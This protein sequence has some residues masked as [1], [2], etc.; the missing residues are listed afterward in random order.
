[1]DDQWLKKQAG[2]EVS[3]FLKE[4]KSAGGFGPVP[5]EMLSSARTDFESERVSDSQTLETIK[6]FYRQ[7]SYVLD[8]HSAVGV[9]TALRS[10]G[11]T[12]PEVPHVA[13]STAHP[14]KFA[15]AV[16]LA[17]K[18]EEGFDFQTK[19]LPAEFANLENQEKRVTFVE[20]NWQRVRELVKR[21]VEEE[22]LEE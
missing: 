1:M 19:V 3:V 6:D 14:A 15:G 18:D 7:T 5:K 20:N 12:G 10:I 13:L 9:A 17:L 4:L 16:E 2:Q 22:L 21:Q 11:R 8:P